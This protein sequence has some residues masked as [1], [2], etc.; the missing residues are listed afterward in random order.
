M[1]NFRK[2]FQSL[3]FLSSSSFS[4]KKIGRTYQ[5]DKF[6]AEFVKYI[7]DNNFELAQELLNAGMPFHKELSPYIHQHLSKLFDEAAQTENSN[8]SYIQ[9]SQKANFIDFIIQNNL[10]SETTLP[11]IIT[12]VQNDKFN[13]KKISTFFKSSSPYTSL[14]VLN[15]GP[16]AQHTN[17]KSLIKKIAQTATFGE[18][19]Y[20]NNTS[21]K[22]LDLIDIYYSEKALKDVH[23]FLTVT[24][25]NNEEFQQKINK[26]NPYYVFPTFS[27]NNDNSLLSLA[28]FSNAMLRLMPAIVSFEVEKLNKDPYELFKNCLNFNKNNT[29]SPEKDY[30][31][32]S[33]YLFKRFQNEI[34]LKMTDSDYLHFHNILIG[35]QKLST[36]HL[37][38][39]PYSKLLDNFSLFFQEVKNQKNTQNHQSLVNE[40]LSKKDNFNV[41]EYIKKH[42]I[43][44]ELVNIIDALMTKYEKINASLLPHQEEQIF[45]E[46]LPQ[47]IRK[48]IDNHLD[49]RDIIGSKEALTQT[50]STLNILNNKVSSLFDEIQFDGFKNLEK[51][52][53]SFRA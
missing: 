29:V 25:A 2:F 33:I 26:S 11:F 34:S 13:I 31:Y 5:L 7:G 16:Y 43:E 4:I 3:T 42:N 37:E 52:Q 1:F 41:A 35:L 39:I 21:K 45:I 10:F 12:S 17:S 46:K 20:Q 36:R 27:L 49:V 50:H 40:L 6:E 18:I 22:N 15:A 44:K 19:F 51:N 9:D 23:R 8:Y 14:F 24:L 38:K 47:T 32:F 48:V 28:P 53:R 30:G